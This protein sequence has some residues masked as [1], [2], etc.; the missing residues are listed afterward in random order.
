LVEYMGEV[1][2]KAEV[3][4]RY[5]KGDVGIYC[6][7]ISSNSIIDS[8]LFR[9]VGSFANASRGKTKPNARFVCNPADSS[10]RLV[11]CRS[12]APGAEIFVS[13][14]QQYWKGSRSHT[15]S[16]IPEWEWDLSSPLEPRA[17][18]VSASSS[19]LIIP[20]APSSSASA[21]PIRPPMDEEVPPPPT[22]CEIHVGP[23][24][25]CIECVPG[26]LVC[27]RHLV[28]CGGEGLLCCNF[29]LRVLCLRH[30]YCPCMPA[31]Q[32]R[33][34]VAL[35]RRAGS[36]ASRRPSSLVSFDPLLCV[37]ILT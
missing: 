29:C 8:A 26:F 28:C 32:R 4:L 19:S 12:I 3:E 6:L 2:S 5:P 13:Y 14:G 25:P 22:A 1:L 23:A 15:T 11:A 21:P 16:G 18:S 30:A 31:I 36:L 20:A 24:V 35:A 10:A 33:R 7:A 37:D 27:A 9:G 34:E 17:I